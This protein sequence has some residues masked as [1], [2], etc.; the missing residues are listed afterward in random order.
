M[1]NRYIS[2]GF[3]MAPRISRVETDAKYKLSPFG[4]TYIQRPQPGGIFLE[5][6]CPTLSTL[7]RS[8]W[9]AIP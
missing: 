2:N 1:W 3:E 4:D 8:F 7:V 5:R 6:I 9:L